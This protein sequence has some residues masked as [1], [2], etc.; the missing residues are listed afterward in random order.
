M[1][2]TTVPCDGER[3]STNQ[4]RIAELA[5]RHAGKGL[6]NIHPFLDMDWLRE[7]YQRTRKNGA[8]GVDGVTWAAYGDNLEANLRTLLQ[9]AKSGSYQ[10]PPVR[11]VHIPKGTE[12][13]TRPIGI[14]TLED[15]VLQRAVLMLLEPIVEQEF[16]D[17]SYAFRPGR[18][19]HQAL[20]RIWRGTM[21]EGMTWIVDVDIQKFFD[22][23]DHGCLR[24]MVNQRVRDG[25]VNRLI[26]KWL[27]AGVMENGHWHEAEQGTPQGGVIS[28]LL[29]NLYLHDVLDVWLKQVVPPYLK[30]KIFLVRFADDLAIGCELRQDAEMLM[31][32]LPKRLGKYGLTMHPEKTRLVAFGPPVTRDGKDRDGN[33]PGTF[34]FLSFTHYWGLSSGGRWTV[35]RKTASKR[36]TRAISVISEWCRDN[37]HRPIREQHKDLCAKVNGHYAYFGITGNGRCIANFAH[38][39]RRRWRYWLDRRG[40][41]VRLS[42]Q[43]FMKILSWLPLPSPRI[44]HSYSAAKP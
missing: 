20:Q 16:L 29:A 35:K 10:A 11:R 22:T 19:A 32:V 41:K 33:P 15:R 44:V 26:G 27:K 36:L 7:A 5:R 8:P 17:T 31:R 14:P 40:G 24:E 43:R 39:V 34:T 1:S 38:E 23:L 12:G 37:R 42:W 2:N 28:P 30:G 13:E 4:A 25:V 18:S 6:D 9:K 21:E 3:V